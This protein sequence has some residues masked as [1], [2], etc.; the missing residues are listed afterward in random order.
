[1]ARIRDPTIWQLGAGDKEKDLLPIMIENKIMMIGPGDVGDISSIDKKTLEKLL[2]EKGINEGKTTPSML[3]SFRDASEGEIVVLRLGSVCFAVGAI[4]GKYEWRKEYG[5]VYSY[6]NR[7]KKYDQSEDYWDLQHVRKVD[8]FV[9]KDE[10]AIYYFRRGIYGRQRFSE[11]GDKKLRNYLKKKGY[12]GKNGKE[13]LSAIGSPAY[14][15]NEWGFPEGVREI[16][17]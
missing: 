4:A 9:L 11:V 10:E 7:D 3:I 8:W 14:H 12:D 6:W 2:K 1:M 17:T 16:K 13:V 5:K 15:I